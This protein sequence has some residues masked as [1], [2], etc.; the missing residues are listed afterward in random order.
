MEIVV[1]V[2]AVACVAWLVWK[3]RAKRRARTRAQTDAALERAWRI[4]LSDPNYAHRRRYEERMHEDEARVR[5]EE[6]M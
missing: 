1:V 2:A 4:V 6:G 3:T 5:K